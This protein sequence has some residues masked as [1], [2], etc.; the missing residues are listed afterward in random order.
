VRALEAETLCEAAV[1]AGFLVAMRFQRVRGTIPPACS[2]GKTLRHRHGRDI[3]KRSVAPRRNVQLIL[4][5]LVHFESYRCCV[6]FAQFATQTASKAPC[7]S[8]RPGADLCRFGGAK[9]ST[10]ADVGPHAGCVAAGMRRSYR[11]AAYDGQDQGV[12]PMLRA[13]SGCLSPPKSS[14]RTTAQATRVRAAVGQ[15]TAFDDVAN[16][17]QSIRPPAMRPSA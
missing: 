3:P 4:G 17:D 12:F 1:G 8:G 16:L 9:V 11:S 2:S 15:S 13:H 14:V 6:R 7:A 5:R 10:E